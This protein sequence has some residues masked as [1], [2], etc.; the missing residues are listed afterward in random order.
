MV[1]RKLSAHKYYIK[2]KFEILKKKKLYNKS[3][4]KEIS[5]QRRIYYLKNK[6]LF[7]ELHKR[8]YKKFLKFIKSSRELY[9]KIHKKDKQI[10][11]KMYYKNNKCKINI[12]RNKYF[13]KRKKSD[14]NF[15]ILCN[16]RTR[17]CEVL[18]GN[19]KLSTTMNLVGCSVDFL[20]QYLEKQFK[21]G[22]TWN[23]HGTGWNGKGMK[24][25]HIDHIIPCASFD[26]S[27]PSE[28]RKCFHY[29]NLQPL[30]AR[31]NFK[32]GKS[33]GRK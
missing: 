15:K 32:K 16:L 29:T 20:K 17:M 27:K 28:Q 3:H 33:Y 8:Y 13:I 23:N 1:N 6:R 9:N 30:W 19:V 12:N 26:L 21:K 25:W 2:N 11:N 5:I 31:E 18:K 7:S 24:E 4:A 14:I 10:Y 22:M